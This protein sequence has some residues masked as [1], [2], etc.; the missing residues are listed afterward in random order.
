MEKGSMG[1]R[2]VSSDVEEVAKGGRRFLYM[3]GEEGGAKCQS[4]IAFGCGDLESPTIAPL[5]GCFLPRRRSQKLK[6]ASGNA[7]A[8]NEPKTSP[9]AVKGFGG[10]GGK[11]HGRYGGAATHIKGVDRKDQVASG[12]DRE[13][14]PLLF[15]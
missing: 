9:G 14:S 1:R 8:A 3:A 11:L 5:P 6:E 15:K 12:N 13:L 7:P 10:G 4:E 2:C